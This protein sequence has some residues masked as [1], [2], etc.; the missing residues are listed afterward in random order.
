MVL[1]GLCVGCYGAPEEAGGLGGHDPGP[2][3]P[4]YRTA[5]EENT[6]WLVTSVCGLETEKYFFLFA[7]M[8]SF[9][10]LR[11]RRDWVLMAMR[12]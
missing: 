11:G 6:G 5:E 10:F 7:Q 8:F 1:P 9:L 12:T 4:L 3:R 2:E